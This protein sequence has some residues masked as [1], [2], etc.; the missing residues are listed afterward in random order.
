MKKTALIGLVPAQVT[1]ERSGD[2]LMSK[3]HFAMDYQ[4]RAGLPGMSFLLH[5]TPTS[6]K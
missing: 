2:P 5:F 6:G 3:F 4:V 1:I